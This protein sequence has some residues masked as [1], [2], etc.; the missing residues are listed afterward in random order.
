MKTLD[1]KSKIAYLLTKKNAKI[2]VTDL[3]KIVRYEIEKN[4]NTY[5]ALCCFA[6]ESSKE[7]NRFY[8]HNTDEMEKVISNF[9]ANCE[10]NAKRKQE[11]RKVR[12]EYIPTSKP[13]DIFVCSWGYEQT[14]IDFYLLLEIKNKTGLFVE[15][16]S[17]RVEGSTYSHG[18][19]CNVVANPD[20]RVGE[21]FKKRIGEG[22]HISLE[23]YKYCHKWDGK[24]EYCSWYN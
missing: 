2:E 6:G 3:Y 18:M 1:Q 13:G 11:R 14:N 23:S 22:E 8:Y 20:V 17:K 19:A 21:A 16:G 5:P 12:A 10:S 9:K 24:P 15:I 4:G 7:Y